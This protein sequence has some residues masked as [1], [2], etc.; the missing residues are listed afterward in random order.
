MGEKLDYTLV[1]PNQ[2]CHHRINTH[3]NPC[4]NNPMGITWPQEGVTITL[5]MSG[6][7]FCANTSLPTQQQL[8]D[9]P[10]IILTYQHDYDPHYIR[11]PKFSRREEEEDLFTGIAA[12]CV[13]ALW[14]KVHETNIDQGLR[15]TVHILSF[16]VTRLLLKVRIADANVPDAARIKFPDEEFFER[17]MSRRAFSQDFRVQRETSVCQS[18]LS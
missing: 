15:N 6:T 13:D 4:M 11:F 2:I 14:I 5:Y 16:V 8:Y 9:F 17:S 7:I 1:R 12:I 10:R 18:I 3:D